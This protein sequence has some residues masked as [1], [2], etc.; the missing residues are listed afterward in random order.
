MQFL[1]AFTTALFLV[2]AIYGLVVAY[3]FWRRRTPLTTDF[4]WIWVGSVAGLLVGVA[5]SSKATWG[6]GAFDGEIALGL[7]WVL[8]AGC[9]LP[10]LRMGK[11]LRND[12]GFNQSVDRDRER[13]RRDAKLLA[14]A[15]ELVGKIDNG[16]NNR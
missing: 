3:R 4:A 5:F 15:E 11:K 12:S 2:S 1:N 9:V 8:W 13:A 10:M 16:F 14:H 6:W 7:R